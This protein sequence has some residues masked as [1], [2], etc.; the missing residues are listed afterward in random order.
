MLL[1]SDRAANGGA[2]LPRLHRHFAGDLLDEQVELRSARC[3]IR[4]EDRGVQAVA[5]RDEP[6]RLPSEDAVRLEL[7]SGLCGACERHDILQSQMVEQIADAA[8]DELQRAR[9]RMS[10][11]IMI[12]RQFGEVAG[13]GAGF[14]DH[15]DA[16][17]TSAEL[18]QHSPD[19]KLKALMWTA[20]PWERS[21]DMLADEGAALRQ[22]LHLPSIR[23]RWFGS[24]RRPLDEKEKS[25]PAPPSM[26]ILPS[27][28][29]R[30]WN[31]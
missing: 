12:G 29:W 17:R 30:R 14:T 8:H 28:R 4:A 23:M 11:S 5:L 16:R 9:R 22:R 21:I 20:T 10:A 27:L 6:H 24:S 7:H 19:G 3:R 15:R 25:V 13:R 26:S 1:R 18:I 2:F 31:S